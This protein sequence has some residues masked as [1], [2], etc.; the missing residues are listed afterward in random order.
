MTFEEVLDQAMAMLQRRGRLTYRTL[1]LHFQLDDEHLETLKD[2]L[3]YGQ[4]L[5]VDEDGRVLVWTGGADVPPGTTPP[6]PQPAPPPAS[7]AATAPAAPPSPD[8][9]RR[10]LTVLFCD[11]VDST[12]LASQLDPEDWREVVRAYQQTCAEV[13]QRFEGHI[14]QYLGDGLLVYFGYPQAHEDDAQRAVRTGLGMMQAM[15][16]LNHRLQQEKGVH[17]AI[18]VGIH[19]GLVIV[20][21]VGGGS[22]Q[23]QLALGE[24]PNLAA[25]LQGLA[26]PDTVVISPATFRLVRGYFTS[27][28][29]GAHSLKGVAAPVQVYRMLGASTAQSR[30]DI[31]GPSGFTPLVGREAEVLLL[32]ERWAH[33]QDGRGQVVLLSG[34]PGIGKSRLVEVL[35]ERVI[36]QGATRLVFRCSPYHQQSVLFPVIDHLQRF[37]H[38]DSIDAPEARLEALEQVLQTSRL[39]L[40]EVIPL[41]AALLSLPHPAHYP[42]LNLPPQRQ[43]QQTHDA[44]VA[45]LLEEAERQPVLAVW[46]DLHW[47]D[48]ST[49]EFLGLVLDQVPTARMLTL[50]TCRPE[51][52]PPWAT[53]SPLTQVTL[54][55]LG[56]PQVEA[57]I[58]SLTGGKALPAAVVEQVVAKTDGVPL[59]VEELVK[60]LLESG[61][62][63]EEA[64]HY[65]LT[66][67]LP[68]LAIPATLHDSLMARLD[69]LSSVKEVAQL[70]ATLGRTF[71]YELLQAVSPLDEATLEQGLRQLVEA[72]LVYQRGAL[73]HATYMFKHALIQEAAYQS[74][75]RSTRQQGH[76]RIAQVLESRFPASVETQPELVAQHYTAAGCHEQAVVYWQRAGQQASDRSANLEAISH[77]TTG[78]ELLKSLPETPQHTQQAVT[79]YI[80]L[81]AALQMTKGYGA[82]EV[83]HAYTQA[84]ALCQQVG[85]TPELVPVLFGLWRFYGVRSQLHT[86]REL[87]ETLL[88]L[89]QRAHDPALAVI[90]HSA[91]GAT[92]LYLGALPAARQHVEEA[93]AHYTPDQRRALVF[94]MGQDPGVSCRTYAAVTLWLMG[95]PDQALAHINDA[96]TLAHELSHP[97]SLAWARCWAAFV[98]QFRRDVLAVHEQAE[99]AV[100]L[101]TAQGFPLWAAHGTSLRGWARAMQGQGEEGMAQVRQGIAAVRATGAALF[102]PYYCTVLAEVCDHLGHTEDGLQ[103]LAEAYTLVE[104]QE[105]RWWEAEVC[106][107]RG[108][109]LR[110]H[111]G[112]P[113]AEAEAWLQRALDVARRQQAKSLELRA[114]MSLSRLWQQQGKRAEAHALLAPVYSWFTEGFDTADLQEARA[115]LDALA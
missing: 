74:L 56:R 99:A 14:A 91:L 70:G 44:L 17:L 42:P 19:T 63:R 61:L 55:R 97:F 78:I 94:R 103:A 33:S 95:Y 105:E 71:A 10:Q 82:P 79:L 9:E 45:W 81:G 16:T 89:A 76:Q 110:K 36:S 114:A 92:W 57:M 52:H 23:E 12:R 88:R 67:P 107:L 32:L 108:V 101:S 7:E 69:R 35:R 87:G 72:E 64:D 5:A 41:F 26:A 48:P 34:E 100:A 62:V 25:R 58:T 86:A 31:A 24:T 43:R 20:G 84:R 51:F 60:M 109:L 85:E 46:E 8:A 50:L 22:R 90:A 18:R 38:W 104:Q 15:A 2:E 39:P 59:F 102:V 66:G 93:I 4:R 68:P 40:E 98:S 54:T 47:A 21:E 6:G 29:L 111:P 75:L 27:Q 73:P 3:I 65:V 80:A 49:L 106:R 13:I 115:L 37:L 1:K 53:H 112:T 30:L 96:P 11:L 28:E 77:C 83:E 113:Q